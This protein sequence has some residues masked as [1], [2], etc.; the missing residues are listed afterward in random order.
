M[1]AATNAT[2][3]GPS[4]Q[5]LAARMSASWAA[6]A[7]SGNP[8]A[9][10]V[11]TTADVLLALLSVGLLVTALRGGRTLRIVMAEGKLEALVAGLPGG[12]FLPGLACR[13]MGKQALYPV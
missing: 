5:A 8:D 7:R 12:V 10:Q 4:A 13:V 1:H 2:D 3:N 6:F 11:Y 9:W